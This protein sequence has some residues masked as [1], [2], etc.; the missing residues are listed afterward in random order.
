MMK[1]LAEIFKYMMDNS[2]N[3]TIYVWITFLT[4]LAYFILI[5]LLPSHLLHLLHVNYLN[6]IT[7][8]LF[9]I[10]L[11]CFFYILTNIV[12]YF[13]HK[14]KQKRIRENKRKANNEVNN[15]LNQK[16][17]YMIKNDRY[18]LDL[19]RNIRDSDN[20]QNVLHYRSSQQAVIIES[21][22]EKYRLIEPATLSDQEMESYQTSEYK[23]TTKGAYILNKIEQMN[24]KTL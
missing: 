9:I 11:F 10:F 2:K 21:L 22:K 16:I 18:A 13:I 8:I 7:P 19:L 23:L 12:I 15:I 4:L 6:K 20:N 1:Y 3:F 5:I 24:N 17:I 14:Y